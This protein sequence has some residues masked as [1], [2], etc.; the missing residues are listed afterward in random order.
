MATAIVI[1]NYNT[2][3]D[4]IG[5]IN[6]IEAHNTAPVKYIVVDNGSSDEKEIKLLD[7]FFIQSQKSYSFLTDKD[8]PSTS[9]PYFTF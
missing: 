2:A 6:S 8:T 4:T 3:S 9:L 5:C 1:L 7:D